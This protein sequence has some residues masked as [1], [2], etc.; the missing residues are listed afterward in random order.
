MQHS[1]R[2]VISVH[3]TEATQ[4]LFSHAVAQIWLKKKKETL[5]VTLRSVF[6]FFFFN[7]NRIL[8]IPFVQQIFK[9]PARFWST[10]S[11]NWAHTKPQRWTQS[12]FSLKWAICFC[13]ATPPIM[14]CTTDEEG[15][16]GLQI[17]KGYVL[18]WYQGC[19]WFFF[20][21]LFFVFGK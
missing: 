14:Y 2:V 20:C 18:F 3:T 9:V 5:T 21:L 15:L 12:T 4:P 17:Y 11:K 19:C 6:F 7:R 10:Y 8:L 1:K 16:N 13:L